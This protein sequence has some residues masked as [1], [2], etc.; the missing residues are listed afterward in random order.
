MRPLATLALACAP[1][2][3]QSDT[4]QRQVILNVIATT[5]K[6]EPVTDL[7]ASEVH[8]R[9]DGKPHPIEFFDFNGSRRDSSP[10]SPGVFVN[11]STTE[12][13]V[14]LFD[15]WNEQLMTTASAWGDIAKAFEGLETVDRIYCYFLTN[16]GNLFPVRPLP[17]PDADPSGE[18]PVTPAQ[19]HAALDQ[20]VQKLN[21]FR[22]VDA[23]D[24]VRRANTTF[25]MLD[26]LGNLMTS[27]AGRKTLIWVTHGVPLIIREPGGPL[28]L[29]N[30]VRNG[31]LSAARA[32]IAIYTVD[33]SAA[34]AGA[35][36]EGVSRATLQMVS[37]ITGG[38]WFGSGNAS[39]ALNAALAD[40]RGAYRL[41]YTS[42]YRPDDKKE[43]K[44]RL[45]STRKNVR[46]LTVE[47]YFGNT[48][49]PDENSYMENA[50]AAQN[51]SPFDATEIRL[52]VVI[53]RDGPKTHFDI[54]VNPSDIYLKEDGEKYQG[55]VVACVSIF[56]GT[57][58]RGSSKPEST[59]LSLTADQLKQSIVLTQDAEFKDANRARVI[60]YDDTLHALGSVT[61]PL[62]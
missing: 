43:H 60:V 52:S 37:S 32:G 33:Q 57:E 31:S 23:L 29:T 58:Y 16:Q 49:E 41:S 54:R 15:R 17:T 2:F 40:S 3:A 53:K 48:A 20:A 50:F 46:L 9:E 35:D 55:R 45:E 26:K 27:I 59:A 21:G 6:N 47:G 22:N 8:V 39:E 19:L 7:Q 4:P 11:R 10:A 36:V 25:A 1:L 38:R 24:P 34:G 62:N 56:S 44:I 61:F 30:T 14:I 18:A 28:D 13:V 5:N 51:R 12:P 42:D